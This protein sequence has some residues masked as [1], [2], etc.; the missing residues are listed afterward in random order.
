VA[1]MKMCSGQAQS[2]CGL[3]LDTAQHEA[4]EI[5]GYGC[6]AAFVVSPREMEEL[7]DAR[8]RR[9]KA[10]ADLEAWSE[11]G[12]KNATPAAAALTDEEVNR[13]VHDAR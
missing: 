13:L 7:L 8:R 12:R 10:V 9:G 5:T 2:L 3:W 6:P 11:Q 1:V 4:V